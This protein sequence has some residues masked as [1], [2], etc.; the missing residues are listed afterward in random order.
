MQQIFKNQIIDPIF[1]YPSR[2]DLRWTRAFVRVQTPSTSM[3]DES[4]WATASFD[5]VAR[6]TSAI[7]EEGTFRISINAIGG[8]T[9]TAGN[10]YVIEP[11]DNN[12]N[13]V[14]TLSRIVSTTLIEVQDPLPQD[15][16]ALSGVYGLKASIELD[17]AQVTNVGQS[18]ARWRVEDRDRRH[19][20]WDQPFLIVNTHTNYTLDSSTLERMYP[21]VQR[22]RPDDTQLDELIETAWTNYVRPDIEGKGMKSNQ[23]KSWERL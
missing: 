10:K 21:M 7:A 14:V 5:N 1:A 4:S 3:P 22:L 9:L 2:I 20:D 11:A 18:I 17:L 8:G 12:P 13:F 15:I 23:I 16:P 19:Y 6:T